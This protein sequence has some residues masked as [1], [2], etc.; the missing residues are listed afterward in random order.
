MRRNATIVEDT[1]EMAFCAGRKGHQNIQTN[2]CD[3]HSSVAIL[4]SKGCKRK[5][6]ETSEVWNPTS[7]HYCMGWKQRICTNKEQ[8]LVKSRR[9]KS[10]SL[11]A[12]CWRALLFFDED[13]PIK[14]KLGRYGRRKNLHHEPNPS[15]D[16][17]TYEF[18]TI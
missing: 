14:S 9:R 13:L 10:T 3:P 8:K 7:W 5:E 6:A 12:S 4:D 2:T 16:T 11:L 15:Q 17:K 18:L 1:I